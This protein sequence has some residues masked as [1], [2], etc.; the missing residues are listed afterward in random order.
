MSPVFLNAL[1]ISRISGWATAHPAP[2]VPTPLYHFGLRSSPFIFNQFAVSLNWILTN[3]WRLPHVMHYLDDFLDVCP[4][5]MDLAMR[6]KTLILDMFSYLNVPIAPEKVE[7]PSTVLTFLGL[8]LDSEQLEIRLPLSKLQPLRD[9][10]SSVL[11]SE[12][13]SKR[14]LASLLGHLSFASRAVPAGRTFL[15][16]MYDWD[17][18]T[19]G[20]KGHHV[21]CLPPSAADDLRGWKSTLQSWTGKSFLL[22]EE[23]TP[24]PALQFQTDASGTLGYGAYLSG[25]W[26]RGDWS[27]DQQIQ[28]ITYKEL[29]AIVI[30]C[31]TWGS[32]W[33]WLR[34]EI[35]CDNQAVV[36]CI[37]SG[38]CRSP[39]VMQLIRA[40]YSICTEHNFLIR[41]V[42]IPGVLNTIADALSRNMLQVFRRLAPE[43]SHR[44][45]VPVL[46]TLD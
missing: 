39:A 7:G 18:A 38:T 6:H 23:W 28:D 25:R 35:Q 17:K 2:L 37:K 26:L 44:P 46:P 45:E 32:E 3:V 31:A 21:L 27:P 41:A 13:L 15:R 33:T 9:H 10:V 12:R 42:H 43:A 5:S 8:E 36:Q 19:R 14:E 1:D 22:H 40:L 20:M 34:I 29:Y 4:P 24:A 11:H 16:R 30:A